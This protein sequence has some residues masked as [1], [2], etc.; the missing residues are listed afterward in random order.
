MMDNLGQTNA[1]TMKVKIH[2]ECLVVLLLPV[3]AFFSAKQKCYVL[4]VFSFSIFLFV[5]ISVTH[6][7]Q[8]REDVLLRNRN[9]GESYFVFLTCLYG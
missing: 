1:T 2:L 3:L 4:P 9:S 5:L 8:L 7:Y 6:I